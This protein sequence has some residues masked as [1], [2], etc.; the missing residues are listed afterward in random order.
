MGIIL[1]IIAILFVIGVIGNAVEQFNRARMGTNINSI[2]KSLENGGQQ[3]V[4]R[5]QIKNNTVDKNDQ[6]VLTAL[7]SDVEFM[8]TQIEYT[9]YDNFNAINFDLPLEDL[10]QGLNAFSKRKA[11]VKNLLFNN[12][13]AV[14]IY[15]LPMIK[16]IA[17]NFKNNND[18]IINK[19]EMIQSIQDS[20]ST[21]AKE[22]FKENRI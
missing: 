15:A 10:N 6:K 5:Q 3:N 19:N 18:Y 20:M 7:K 21:I 17:K 22:V 8:N 1:I 16:D 4:S 9:D 14:Y 2:R 12:Q 11:S 13:G